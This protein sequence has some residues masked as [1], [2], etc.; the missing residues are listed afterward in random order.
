M[1]GASKAV[2]PAVRIER[3]VCMAGGRETLDLARLDIAHGE[4]I[5]IVGHNGAGKSTLLRMLSGF[6]APARGHAWVLGYRLESKLRHRDLRAL[7]C[8]VAQVMQ[9]VHLVQ[10]LSALENVLIGGLGRLR[11]WRSWTR[12]HRGEDI[13][14][15]E[16]ALAAVGLSAKADV[17][18]D[19]L[20][21]GERQ[22]VAVARMLMQ[23]PRLI[24]ADEPTA[25]LDPQAAA[26]V[27]RLLAQAAAG[28]TL[29]TVVHNP[30]LLPLLADR[31]IGLKHGRLAFDAPLSEVDD[32]LMG[33]LYRPDE[34]G[35]IVRTHAGST[36]AIDRPMPSTAQ[37]ARSA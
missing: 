34:P 29:I 16:A 10:R 22:K 28:A 15:A 5:A 7:R 23:Q 30:S 32:R 2:E 25:S 13:A 8:A 37:T 17:R 27:C 26:E 11:G 31:V 3:L 35:S 21:G 20:S 33:R 4:R 14:A 36:Q 24:L 19:R 1:N 18:A 6:A 9:G 12:L